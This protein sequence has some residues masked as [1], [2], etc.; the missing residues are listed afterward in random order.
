M[1]AIG[2]SV[3]SASNLWSVLRLY[4]IPIG[5]GIPAGVLAARD[6]GFTW[7]VSAVLYFIS[8][9][10]LAC[11]FEPLLMIFIAL[12]KRSLRLQK[13]GAVMK[14]AV[15]KSTAHYGTT[16]GALTLIL[17]A[18]GADPMTGRTVAVAAGH[19]FV[20]GWLFAIAGDM[21][22]FG[23]LMVSTLW[24]DGILGDGTLTTFIILA[25][26][27]GVPYLIQGFKNRKNRLKS[28]S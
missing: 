2:S 19:G 18:F 14:Q 5:G 27:I 20:M 16:G 21:L 25:A 9:V 26:M 23:L 1:I 24:L 3:Y 15:Q 28:N 13:I 4:L 8:D 7:Q 17:I 6:H 12:S 10:I 22:Y 11:V